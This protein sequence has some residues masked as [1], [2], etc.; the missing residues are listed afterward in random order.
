MDELD[1]SALVCVRDLRKEYVQRRP[2]TQTKFTVHALNGVDLTIRRGATLALVGESAA[3][4]STLVRCLSLVEKP[5]SGEIWWNDANLLALGGQVLFSMRR[6]IQVIFQDPTSAL[7]PGMSAAEIIEEPLAIQKIGTRDERH[8]HAL[9]LM[10]QVGVPSKWAGK[11]PM[12]FSGGQ[13]QRLAIARA[14]ALEPQLLILDEALSNLDL[15][16]QE[17][18][19]RLLCDLQALHGLTYV[20]VA[21]DL[22]MVAELADE[23]AVMHEGRIVEQKSVRDIFDHPEHH[24][25]QDLLAM[26]PTVES[27]VAGREGWSAI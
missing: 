14:L 3:G 10:E 16:N 4:K 1:K 27:I 13:R 9:E 22:R 2:L 5:T 26:A 12:E 23:V 11:L 7:N 17:M 6:R 25:T 18:I 19:L 24:Y 21:H 20:H 15:A 8:T